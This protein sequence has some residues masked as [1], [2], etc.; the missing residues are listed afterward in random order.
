VAFSVINELE[1]PFSA[2]ITVDCWRNIRLADI[3]SPTG[4]CSESNAV[5]I[6]DQQ[7]IEDNEG[8]CNKNSIFS[9]S[10]IG[11]GAVFTRITPSDVQGET[12]G[13]VIAYGEQQHYNNLIVGEI[14]PDQIS[15][16]AWAAWNPQHI[17][18]VYDATNE[19][20]GEPHIDFIR[21]PNLQNFGF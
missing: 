7:C 18:N 20:F 2:T 4:R 19:Q 16:S 21:S 3:T 1:Q 5:C 14:D 15:N 17:N 8:F 6:T 13:G 10:V 9:A 12:Q 11:S